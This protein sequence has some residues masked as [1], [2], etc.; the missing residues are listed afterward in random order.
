[1]AVYN[2][3]ANRFFTLKIWDRIGT[4]LME[5]KGWDRKA[6]KSECVCYG[7]GRNIAYAM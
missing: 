5:D 7:T 2:E 6:S 3:K 1:M 4:N